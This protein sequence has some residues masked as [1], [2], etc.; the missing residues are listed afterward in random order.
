MV[1]GSNVNFVNKS[2]VQFGEKYRETGVFRFFLCTFEMLGRH[3]ELQLRPE[4]FMDRM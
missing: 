1:Y 2:S 3:V 4:W